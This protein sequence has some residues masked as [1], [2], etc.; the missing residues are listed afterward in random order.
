MRQITLEGRPLHAFLVQA[1][2]RPYPGS[3]G[4]LDASTDP[5]EVRPGSLVAVATGAIGGIVV[6]DVDPRNGGDRWFH[7]HRS[8][9]PTTRTHETRSDGGLHLI[10]RYRPGLRSCRLAAGVDFLSDGKFI[11]WWPSAFRRVLVESPVAELPLALLHRNS[12][13]AVSATAEGE[14]AGR[15]SPTSPSSASVAEGFPAFLDNGKEQGCSRIAGPTLECI[16]EPA[17]DRLA[18]SKWEHPSSNKTINFRR[19]TDRILQMVEQAKPGERNGL[20]FWAT[21]T[22]RNTV[23]AEG[24]LQPEVAVQLLISAATVCGLVRDD[25]IRSVLATIRS[26]L[27]RRDAS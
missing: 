4:Y 23:I 20:L 15:F 6:V 11:V 7:E 3:H 18:P 16:G 13:S 24:K 10:F 1:N 2:K 22:L 9:I 27:K 17:D 26:G 25:G 8:E 5:L 14:L 21:C 19:R 12:H